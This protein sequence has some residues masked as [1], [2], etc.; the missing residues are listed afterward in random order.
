MYIGNS[1]EGKKRPIPSFDESEAM[2]S[3][4]KELGRMTNREYVLQKCKLIKHFAQDKAFF[5]KQFAR[6]DKNIE[7]GSE[8]QKKACEEAGLKDE[9]AAKQIWKMGGMKSFKSGLAMKRKIT[10]CAIQNAVKSSM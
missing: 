3:I 5:V 1:N 4:R 6:N 8:I 9:L 10:M 2:G 7:I